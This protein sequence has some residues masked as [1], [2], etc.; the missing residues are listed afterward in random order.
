MNAEPM[1][2]PSYIFGKILTNTALISFS[3][4]FVLTLSVFRLCSNQIDVLLTYLRT[5]L[6]HGAET[7]LGI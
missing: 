3:Q 7:F 2:T 5:Y 1:L 4:N 6:L